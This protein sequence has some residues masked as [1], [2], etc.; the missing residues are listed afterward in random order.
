MAIIDHAILEI[1]NIKQITIKSLFFKVVFKILPKLDF[2]SKYGSVGIK[3]TFKYKN[4]RVII[5]KVIISNEKL[6]GMIFTEISSCSN[7][8][9]I[10]RKLNIHRINVPS[11][12]K[13]PCT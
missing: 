5:A 13:I 7:T 4:V 3:K 8:S 10:T 9:V 12:L 1:P 2:I 6:G 11:K